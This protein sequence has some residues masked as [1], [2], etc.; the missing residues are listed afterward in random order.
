M[1]RIISTVDTMVIENEEGE[2]FI[3]EVDAPFLHDNE[4]YISAKSPEYCLFEVVDLQNIISMDQTKVL[5][6]NFFSSC[7]YKYQFGQNRKYKVVGLTYNTRDE[8]GRVS[9][10]FSIANGDK[11]RDM[12]SLIF[13]SPD[14]V[15]RI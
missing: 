8:G 15:K 7:P 14:G 5:A 10:K 1:E 3:L 12:V 4:R 2:Q 13:T 6:N 9:T 11:H